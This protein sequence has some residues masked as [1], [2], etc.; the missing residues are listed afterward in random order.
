MSVLT[1]YDHIEPI[2]PSQRAVT[3]I[4]LHHVERD[5]F[6]ETAGQKTSRREN[7]YVTLGAMWDNFTD[8][9]FR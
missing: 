3:Y 7:I 4:Y 9:Y 1:K 8:R 2:S 5:L 6:T